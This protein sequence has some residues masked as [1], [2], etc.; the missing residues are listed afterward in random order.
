MS[1]RLSPTRRGLGYILFLG[2]L[3]FAAWG[4]SQVIPKT[5]NCVVVFGLYALAEISLNETNQLLSRA[6]GDEEVP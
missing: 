3:L 5:F 2:N 6:V 1:R 4:S